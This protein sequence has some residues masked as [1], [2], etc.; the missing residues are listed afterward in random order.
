MNRIYKVI[1]S[2]AKNCYVVA[3]ELAK[4]RT[5]SPKSSVISPAIVAG[6]LACVL[7]FGA[8]MPAYAGDATKVSQ[9]NSNNIIGADVWQWLHDNGLINENT[10]VS[11]VNGYFVFGNNTT[12]TNSGVGV[13]EANGFIGIGNGIS[14]TPRTGWD[15]RYASY[16]LNSLTALPVISHSIAVGD[17][18]TL[19][20]EETIGIGYNA[21]SEGYKSISIGSGAISNYERNV[22][23]GAEAKA[24]G[25][26]TVA[27]GYDAQAL[28]AD[29]P[30]YVAPGDTNSPQRSVAIGS[31]SRALAN[32]AVAIGDNAVAE[33][34]KAWVVSIGANS[35]SGLL[36][37]SA[38]G[39]GSKAYGKNSVAIG[40]QAFAGEPNSHVDVYEKMN[41]DG[42]VSKGDNYGT[43]ALA[44][45][46]MAYAPATNS[47]ALG[48]K[49]QALG[50]NSFAL[51]SGKQGDTDFDNITKAEGDNSFAIGYLTQ[52]K[53][54]KSGAVGVENK[55]YGNSVNV[56]GSNNT[57]DKGTSGTDT[58]ENVLV[59][60][61]KNSASI[62][63]K[64][65]ASRDSGTPTVS[66]AIGI[67]NGVIL[68]EEN[69]TAI[70]NGS[71]S[72]ALNSF[73][74]GQ[75]AEAAAENTTAIGFGAT[76]S[77]KNALAFGTGASASETDTVAVGSS[78]SASETN[79]VAIGSFASATKENSVAIGAGSV[80]DVANTVS[81][82]KA[83]VMSGETVISPEVTRRIMHV[84]AGT[85]DTDAVNVKQL[86]DMALDKANVDA[87]NVGK[88]IT[89]PDDYF[90]PGTTD[91]EKATATREARLLNQQAWGEALGGLLDAQD[92]THIAASDTR[93]VQGKDVHQHVTPGSDG[94]YIAVASTTGQN[95]TA[96]DEALK[97]S[98][99]SSVKSITASGRTV[100]YRK[101]DGSTGTFTTQDTTYTAGHG[102]ILTETEFKAK[103][104]KNTT[105][106]ANGI[107]ALDTKV[108]AGTGMAM[109]T[110]GD[111][112]DANN[113]RTY[114]VGLSTDTKDKLD[115]AL[116]SF[117]TAVDGGTAQTI[118]KTA[119]TANFINGKN[120][121]MTAGEAGIT[122]AT[123]E[124]VTF[125]SVTAG[126]G[127]SAVAISG[128]GV[129]VGGA[130]YINSS[131]LNA[132]GKTIANVAAGSANTDAVNV[133]Q[134]KELG[135]GKANVALDNITAA[136]HNV[137]KTDAKSAINVK[138]NMDVKVTKTDVNGVDTYSLSV[139]KDGDVVAGDMKLV[140]GETVYNAIQ[141]VVSDTETALAGKA[142]V[143]LDN[144][145]EAGHNVIK[146]DAQSAIKVEGGEN[147]SVVK[148]T[149]NGVDIYYVSAEGGG[150]VAIGDTGLITGNTAYVALM[151]ETR[152]DKK[153]NYITMENNA[154][155]NLTA[156]DNQ[157]K[158]NADAI[159]NLGDGSNKANITLDN[160]T[161]D[162][163]NVIKTDAKSAINV[164]GNMD[165]KVTKTDVNGV[166]TYNLSVEKD[167]TV[168]G[169][170]TKLV[171][172]DTV[173]NA[174][175][176][177]ISDTETSLNGKANVN[178]DNIN[179]DG[180]NVVRTIAKNAVKVADGENTTVSSETDTDGNI[181]YKVKTNA[182]GTITANNTGL[183]NGGTVYNEVRPASDGNYITVANTT[184]QNLTALD[185]KLKQTYELA[186]EASTQ[187]HD[188][189][190]VHY[191]S[192]SKEKVTLQG[193][194]GTVLTNLKDG[195]VS[196]T[197][198][199]AVTGRQLHE[200]KQTTIENKQA[201]DGLTE[202]VGTT[203]DGSYVKSTNT[204]GQNLNTLD[205]QLK[206]NS[207]AISTLRETTN[208]QLETKTNTDMSNITETGKETI[209][210]L[211]R[212]SVNVVSEDGTVTVTES[213]VDTVRT[214]DL[215][216]V[217]DG[218]VESGNTGIVTG[219][220]VYDAI[221]KSSMITLEDN[222]IRIG[223]KNNAEII[224]ITNS[225]GE[226]R[227]L[228]GI[229]TDPN[230]NNSAA[231]VGY[232][233]AIGEAVIN[234]VNG[235]FRRMDE[236]INKTG[237][238]AAAL[239]SLAP[240]SFDGGEKW[241]L[242]AAVGN[243]HGET[244]A[245]IGAFYRP[246]DNIMINLRSSLGSGNNMVGAGVSFAL[247]KG[248][249]TGISKKQLVNTINV[250][251]EKLQQAEARIAE[252]DR[253][254]AEQDKKIAELEA[255]VKELVKERKQ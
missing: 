93:L 19:R 80:A 51:G 119:D 216:V 25:Y 179:A 81:V 137:I 214:F 118:S 14:A 217:K 127:D 2:K 231:N 157:V 79:A 24:N 229:I 69:A 60:G 150:R 100:T 31:G 114:K 88:S 197:S 185:A 41:P 7:S 254:A 130:T 182:T 241:A 3:S 96:L 39:F 65:S 43:N 174:I 253:R 91:D 134:L 242:S 122:V 138:G 36:G 27:I 240:A 251:A 198:T 132:N 99:D 8:V 117:K 6:V 90:A 194:N 42:V 74:A 1:W 161:A 200:V 133:S 83:K 109:E 105:V 32:M 202:K 86:R 154:G 249:S 75:D 201:I 218:K 23:I 45:G 121:E 92:K 140:T 125:T 77:K 172:G 181:T 228:H 73:A 29:S 106:D 196:A 52:V 213:N 246:A 145:T 223:A 40:R 208:T 35:Y 239:A 147:A 5:K 244:A 173:Y 63:N 37:A 255:I 113:V 195:E 186:I 224:D 233:N 225:N 252:Q 210:E 192:V 149:R 236:K 103:A 129:Q 144:I 128:S 168:V 61:N 78:A 55:I 220:T 11:D 67:G 230:D 13:T 20:E 178:L 49:A 44:I 139:A 10:T 171:T 66:G 16:M 193:E 98:D 101:G 72:T 33:Q 76:S 177:V 226:G 235:G 204:V 159:K 152:P 110:S 203:N 237:A 70:G 131:G 187:G 234:N 57:V 227:V 21:L 243:Y 47:F 135:D 64:A 199:D 108:E 87:S 219:G 46:Y 84:T 15:G 136:G 160:I 212:G 166:D 82:G 143:G 191:D 50:E 162:G 250:Q 22:T 126:T 18:V 183:L 245:A 165:V 120:M 62:D 169:G 102:L 17:G 142:N 176:D 9:N 94:N 12:V 155:K 104:G 124:N 53:G 167:G 207:D 215:S 163:H 190:A 89:L 211:A 71:K 189:N 153:G 58:V 116:A 28:L 205:S 158:Q 111:T 4:S 180:V 146:L 48:Y 170:D 85:D 184:G 232:V 247:D 54:I 107:H 175:Q 222:T 112:P 141:N 148:Q 209:R 123:K 97:D 221:Q 34:K 238:H 248:F 206:N 68:G 38:I 156:L 151:N 95:L 26:R 56:F 188:A 30:T 59:L 115:N 164:K